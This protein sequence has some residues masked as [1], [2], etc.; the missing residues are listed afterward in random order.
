MSKSFAL[1]VMIDFHLQH[2]MRGDMDFFEPSKTRQEFAE[3]CDINTLMARYEAG[4]AITHVNKAMP[5]YMDVTQLPDMRGYLDIMR[6]ASTAFFS[7][8][9][10]V[11]R[12]FDN[13]PQKFVDFAQAPEN[14][15][16]MRGWGL[17]PPVPVEEPPIR[18]QMVPVAGAPD[19]GDGPP[20][21]KPQ[22]GS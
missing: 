18:V 21:P 3:E 4:G 2:T 17:A 6:E 19:L 1:P 15:D 22:K 5:V 11:R 20:A 13:D 10:N 14:I 12:E 9:A 16:R 8:P 7:L